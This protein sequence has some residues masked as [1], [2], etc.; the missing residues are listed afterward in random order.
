[1]KDS[2]PLHS[3][4]VID[5]FVVGRTPE[6][7]WSKWQ[8]LWPRLTDMFRACPA[9]G[10]KSRAAQLI[11]VVSAIWSSFLFVASD[12]KHPKRRRRL[13]GTRRMAGDFVPSAGNWCSRRQGQARRA[14]LRRTWPCSD[15]RWRGKLI[16]RR[17]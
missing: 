10:V 13:S 12:I 6:K 4:E 2:P 7:V 5:E 17:S 15:A 14:V 11:V 8:A 9:C 16:M 3:A 1:M